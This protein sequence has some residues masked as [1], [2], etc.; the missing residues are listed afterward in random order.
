MKAIVPLALSTIL[1]L[2]SPSVAQEGEALDDATAYAPDLEQACTPP[3][4]PKLGLRVLS[5][6][7]RED[8]ESV[9]GIILMFTIK[10]M[11]A[12]KSWRRF[13]LT[14]F[15]AADRNVRF[16]GNFRLELGPG[17]TA[18]REH[19]WGIPGPGHYHFFTGADAFELYAEVAPT[20]TPP[21]APSTQDRVPDPIVLDGLEVRKFPGAPYSALIQ[22]K[23]HGTADTTRTT[24]LGLYEGPPGASKLVDIDDLSVERR[25]TGYAAF[26]WDPGLSDGAS[27][28]SRLWTG[29]PDQD[30]QLS[31]EATLTAPPRRE[32]YDNTAAITGVRLERLPGNQSDYIVFF[33]AHGGANGGRIRS[34]RVVV[35]F[36]GYSDYLMERPPT[37]ELGRVRYDLGPGEAGT[38]FVLWGAPIKAPGETNE[39][40][41]FIVG[42]K[43]FPVHVTRE[44]AT[45]T[46]LTA[47][48]LTVVPSGAK[49]GETV[50]VLLT[51][52]NGQSATL[53]SAFP[54]RYGNVSGGHE[55]WIGM[56][57]FSDVKPG[58]SVTEGARYT[59][60]ADAPATI[61]F[62]AG[63]LAVR[64]A[65]GVPAVGGAPVSSCLPTAGAYWD[66]PHDLSVRI[67]EPT[68]G[69][70]VNRGERFPIRWRIDDPTGD[71]MQIGYIVTLNAPSDDENVSN[72]GQ[73][74]V[75][76]NNVVDRADAR[77]R[78]ATGFEL[79]EAEFSWVVL[80][81]GACDK[82][83]IEV[84]ATHLA[85]GEGKPK[86]DFVDLPIADCGFHQ[87][88]VEILEP[89]DGSTVVH[90]A[91][92]PIKWRID[93][94]GV[95][96]LLKVDYQ[97][98]VDPGEA[99]EKQVKY[100]GI[101]DRRAYADTAVPEFEFGEGEYGF[102]GYAEGFRPAKLGIWV[103]ASHRIEGPD[104]R[105]DDYVEVV[106]VDA[107]AP[108]PP[109]IV[110]A[111]AIAAAAFGLAR[112]QQRA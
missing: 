104:E 89:R 25:G 94:G 51:A 31:V 73:Q 105:Y 58:E 99:T 22:L 67:L 91:R 103:T 68:D 42:G 54:V 57:R 96:D 62:S 1:F 11:D 64:Y 21:A 35:N 100:D 2:A 112:R 93:D 77:E 60:P 43:E 28:T 83:R 108:S 41:R 102:T 23:A 18:V 30:P 33:D 106:V 65:V 66:V 9:N 32:P 71:L 78:P 48:R 6:Q 59:I 61:V 80:P 55:R 26:K 92:F 101:V 20:S 5:V 38:D 14:Y 10:N 37:M 81:Q 52:A 70:I 19:P 97:V 87:L 27:K 85:G 75:F 63:G 95:W 29:L 86:S 72:S 90:G 12:E 16:V 50:A 46:S 49:A 45:P 56:A 39:T 84:F 44:A 36:T 111:T 79:G 40:V 74:V 47:T 107:S 82:L 69:T 15:T 110:I 3:A 53:D 34:T 8:H 109:L 13:D 24:V 88:S 76:T 7:T 98:N 17:E 4:T